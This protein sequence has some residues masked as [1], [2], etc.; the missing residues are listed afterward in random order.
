MTEPKRFF[1]QGKRYLVEHHKYESRLNFEL[2]DR[3]FWFKINWVNRWLQVHAG[4]RVV[5]RTKS[6]RPC[7]TEASGIA[8]I[9]ARQDVHWCGQKLYSKG[10]TWLR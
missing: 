3:C 6:G 10:W 4:L 7:K 1:R 8:F 2:F 5:R 9:F